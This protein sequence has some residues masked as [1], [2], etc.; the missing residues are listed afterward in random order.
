MKASA[1]CLRSIEHWERMVEKMKNISE[2]EEKA[3]FG[4][5]CFLFFLSHSERMIKAN[6]IFNETWGISDCVLCGKFY[7]DDCFGCPLEMLGKGCTN[8]SSPWHEVYTADS[9]REWLN[10]ARKKML[11]ALKRAYEYAKALK[12]K[13]NEI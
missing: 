4:N 1:L 8:E 12:R 10:R 13:I 11:P 7:D 3:L 6:A 9:K 5:E 2:K